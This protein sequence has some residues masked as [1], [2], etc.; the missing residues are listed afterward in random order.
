M[1]PLF[2]EWQHDKPELTDS[3]QLT[4]DRIKQNY[5]YRLG[6]LVRA[7]I[8]KMVVLSPWLSLAGYYEPP[9]RACML[10]RL[11]NAIAT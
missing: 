5:L 11:R 7:S 9:F 1:M 3:E 10:K 4:L 8:V 2:P 6:Y